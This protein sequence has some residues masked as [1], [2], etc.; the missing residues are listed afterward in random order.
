MKIFSKTFYLMKKRDKFHFFFLIFISTATN[1]FEISSLASLYP[2]ISILLDN[3][4]SLYNNEFLV[5]LIDYFGIKE[6]NTFKFFSIFSLILFSIYSSL[7]FLYIFYENK[8][9]FF[10]TSSY[11]VNL[12]IDYIGREY[13]WFL[14][15]DSTTLTKNIIEEVSIVVQRIIKSYI[16]LIANFLNLL[17][18][19]LTIYFFSTPKVIIALLIA[20]IPYLIVFFILSSFIRREGEKRYFLNEKRFGIIKNIFSGIKHIKISGQEKIFYKLYQYT[21]RELA[22]VLTKFSVLSGLPRIIL[23]LVFFISIVSLSL[24]FYSNKNV[25]GLDN[26]IPSLAI[27]ALCTLRLIPLLQNIFKSFTDIRFNSLPL[28]E[29]Y[30]DKIKNKTSAQNYNFSL[31]IKSLEFNKCISLSNIN[32]NYE[33]EK[34][35][36]RIKNFNFKIEKGKTYGIIGK[37]GSG[38]STIIDLI[39]FLLK[40]TQG[41]LL[42]DD[43]KIG[44]DNYKNYQKIISYIPQSSF[45]INDTVL[46]NILLFNMKNENKTST[47]KKIK[48]I[49]EILKIVLLDDYI[50]NQNNGLDTRIG[51]EGKFLSGGLRQRLAIARSIFNKEKKLLILDE[52]T[53][54]LDKETEAQIM[55][56]L[57][58][59]SEFTKLIVTHRVETL[60]DCDQIIIIDNGQLIEKGS[61]EELKKNSLRFQLLLQDNRTS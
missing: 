39:C 20:S 36:F 4:E 56:N 61:F 40:P 60:K 58:K 55:M 32:F 27:I 57:S 30:F 50:K 6:E 28:S 54:A 10:K 44:D 48:N 11:S 8:F 19:I 2:F 41:D 31:K 23:E 13:N 25:I 15:K 16:N 49:N 35:I 47:E 5:N 34:E 51:D 53:N 9:I 12:L 43:T 26:F 3:S 14:N 59:L 37:S 45:F 42:I 46:N 22:G 38:K 18:L 24:Y 21:A 29:I 1:I 33:I 52:A 7:K 17:F